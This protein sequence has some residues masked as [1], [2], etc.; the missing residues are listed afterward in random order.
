MTVPGPQ[1]RNL[2]SGSLNQQKGDADNMCLLLEE[3]G[4]VTLR[5]NWSENFSTV[6]S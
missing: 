3:G 4:D 2:F 1:G 6:F 5:G